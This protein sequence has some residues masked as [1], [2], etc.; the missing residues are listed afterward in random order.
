MTGG[1]LAH[2]AQALVGA[3]YRLHGRNRATGLDCIGVLA[4]A[5]EA[6][7][8]QA[9]L[10]SNYRLRSRIVPPFDAIASA[11]GLSAAS[12]PVLPGDVLIVRPGPCQQ[13]L[14]IA[15]GP[16]QFVHAHIALKRIVCGPLRPDWP[17][18]GHWR[19]NPSPEEP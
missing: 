17:L 16:Q 1:D 3:P 18:L 12:G 15:S 8:R 6:A 13:H 14:L 7:G 5:L 11:N 2:A 10:P 19:L 9:A 4:C